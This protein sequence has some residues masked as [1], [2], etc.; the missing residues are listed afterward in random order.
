MALNGQ[1]SAFLLFP[2][3]RDT[4]DTSIYTVSVN[5]VILS[6]HVRYL[7]VGVLIDSRL[8]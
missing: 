8:S 6:S 4:E 3:F 5:N 1:K 7:R 2:K